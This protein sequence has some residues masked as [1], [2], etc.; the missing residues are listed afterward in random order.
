MQAIIFVCVWY[1]GYVSDSEIVV[2]PKKNITLILGLF[3]VWIFVH[4]FDFDEFVVL[5]GFYFGVKN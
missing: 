3:L 1:F 5:L 2:C 4:H